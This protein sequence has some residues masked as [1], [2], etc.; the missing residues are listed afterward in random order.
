MGHSPATYQAKRKQLT[1]VPQVRS[2][3]RCS[4]VV[5]LPPSP[6]ARRH[7]PHTSSSVL[8]TPK[9]PPMT[10]KIG[11]Y[12]SAGQSLRY[13]VPGTWGHQR[14]LPQ[15]I[16]EKDVVGQCRPCARCTGSF[17]FSRWNFGISYSRLGLNRT[18]LSLI[19]KS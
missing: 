17:K 1:R 19:G 11:M 8:R 7:L 5:A 16:N 18:L 13:V 12:F 3:A 2:S 6:S 14:Q 10:R 9:T 15:R 4:S